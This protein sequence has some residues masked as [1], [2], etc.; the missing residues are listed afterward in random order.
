MTQNFRGKNI[1]DIES[2]HETII[3]A[4]NLQTN[5]AHILKANPT[6]SVTSQHVNTDN[7]DT[8]I[9]KKK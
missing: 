2:A 3:S 1:K 4:S 7:F 9:E 5:I 6:V 8:F